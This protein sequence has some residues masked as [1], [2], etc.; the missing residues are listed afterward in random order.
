[1]Y[2]IFKRIFDIT[3]SLISLL[4]IMPICLPIILI[5]KFTGEGEIFYLQKRIGLNNNYFNIIKFATMLKN[6]PNMGNG[7][8]TIVNDPR[9]TKFGNILRKSKINELPQII[10]ILKGDMS[11]IGPRPLPLSDFL[12]YSSDLQKL[13]YQIKPGLTGIGSVIF[14]DEEKY[15]NSRNLTAKDIN[16]KYISPYKGSLELWYQSNITFSTDM[17]IL[18]LT[19]WTVIKSDSHLAYK[20][21][22]SLPEKP[23][24]LSDVWIEDSQ[25]QS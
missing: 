10:N 18:F 19:F 23:K 1:M 14:R 21:F 12:D 7:T 3:I 2:L 20:I 16:K 22:K 25:H 13:I 11:F 9:V 4:I 17:T 24:E 6:S 8:I 5:L 15:F